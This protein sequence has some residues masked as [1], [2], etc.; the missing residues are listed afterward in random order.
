[1]QVRI[2]RGTSLVLGGWRAWAGEA[3]CQVD[4]NENV[5]KHEGGIKPFS[6]RQ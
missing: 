6:D 4:E 3:T 1:M 5:L 2:H